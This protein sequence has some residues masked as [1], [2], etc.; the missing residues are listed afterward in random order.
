MF[1]F[2]REVFMVK[3]LPHLGEVLDLDMNHIRFSQTTTGVWEGLATLVRELV[4]IIAWFWPVLLSDCFRLV[5][6]WQ[7]Y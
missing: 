3:L 2:G 4:W 5:I 7:K 1:L 6:I